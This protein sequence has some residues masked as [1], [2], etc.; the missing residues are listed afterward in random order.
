MMFPTSGIDAV[1]TAGVT[2]IG[3]PLLI[4]SDGVGTK[5]FPGVI[6]CKVMNG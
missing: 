4:E 1:L 6:A 2:G 3:M 5:L